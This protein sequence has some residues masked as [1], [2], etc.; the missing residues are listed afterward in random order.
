VVTALASE[1]RFPSGVTG[2]RESFPLA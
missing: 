1:L 2:P